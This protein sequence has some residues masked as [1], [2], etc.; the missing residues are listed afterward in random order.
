MQPCGNQSQDFKVTLVLYG[1][2]VSLCG[3]YTRHRV[4]SV[5]HL[6][7]HQYSVPEG[8]EPLGKSPLTVRLHASDHDAIK[9]MGKAGGLFVRNAI[10]K[11]LQEQAQQQQ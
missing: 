6:R 11:A 2:T 7:Q 5:Q 4:G 8:Q 9:A 1:A 3:M 10:R